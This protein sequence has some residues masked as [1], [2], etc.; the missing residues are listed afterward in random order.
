MEGHPSRRYRCDPCGPLRL[1]PSL[2]FESVWQEATAHNEVEILGVHSHDKNL[3]LGLI[4]CRESGSVPSW[5][6]KTEMAA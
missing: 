3:G 1:N 4:R 5:T 2:M 6:F